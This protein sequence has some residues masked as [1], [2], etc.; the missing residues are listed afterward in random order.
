M[1]GMLMFYLPP[2]GLLP[3]LLQ[4]VPAENLLR[5]TVPGPTPVNLLGNHHGLQLVALAQSFNYRA[6]GVGG[7]VG[8]LAVNVDLWRDLSWH[9]YP[10]GGI[11][12]T[13]PMPPIRAWSAP[14]RYDVPKNSRMSGL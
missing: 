10:R 9:E 8:R 13:L 3:Q 6:A 7:D 2:E 4:A 1:T 14:G 11:P 12:L 5:V